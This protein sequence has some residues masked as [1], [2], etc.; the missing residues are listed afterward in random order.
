MKIKTLLIIGL[1]I[2]A[3]LALILAPFAS[4]DPDGLERVA[5]NLEFMS[6]APETGVWDSSPLPDYQIPGLSGG[7]S[8]AL[9]G[10]L[11]VVITYLVGVGAARLLTLRRGNEGEGV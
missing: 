10:L 8:T 1:A 3:A 4:P 6:E 9:A 2:S 11:G 5:E 7:V